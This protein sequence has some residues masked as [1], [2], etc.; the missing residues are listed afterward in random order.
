MMHVNSYLG[1]HLPDVLHLVLHFAQVSASL[2]LIFSHF[3]DDSFDLLRSFF[4]FLLLFLDG[5]SDSVSFS[6]NFF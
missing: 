2:F 1:Y 4:D 5:E 6:L 3:A